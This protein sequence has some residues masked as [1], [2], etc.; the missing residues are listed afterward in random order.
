MRAVTL[1]WLLRHFSTRPDAGSDDCEK[2][3]ADFGGD[4][5]FHPCQILKK[6]LREAKLG[7]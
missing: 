1:A 5:M 2:T 7:V 3:F 4:G 6:T